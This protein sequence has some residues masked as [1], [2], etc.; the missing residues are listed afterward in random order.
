VIVA[1]DVGDAAEAALEEALE[2]GPPVNFGFVERDTDSEQGALA[3]GPDAH[4]DEHGTVEQLAV[5]ADLFV[6]RIQDEIGEVAQGAV[7][8]LL[9]FGVE[10][11]GARA[12]ISAMAS[13]RAC[14]ERMPFSR[15]LG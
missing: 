6:A 13:L 9:K 10:E 4:G 5:L 15:A 12:D 14:S 1:G 11:L 2:K 8:P 3:I 7:A